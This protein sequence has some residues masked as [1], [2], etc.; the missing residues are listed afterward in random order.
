MEVQDTR[1]LQIDVILAVLKTDKQELADEI[2]E[3]RSNVSRVLS[4]QRRG[5]R[6]KKKLAKAICRRVEELL[7]DA[8]SP[9]SEQGAKAA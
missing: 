4:G 5:A 2:K 6:T 8:P 3:D 1:A 9:D 7:L